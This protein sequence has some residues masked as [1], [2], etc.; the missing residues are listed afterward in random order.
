MFLFQSSD[1][2]RID[3]SD[4]RDAG[5]ELVDVLLTNDCRYF[6]TTQLMNA[7]TQLFDSLWSHIRRS[8]KQDAI[9][10]F[11][12]PRPIMPIFFR[13]TS[14]P[15][16]AIVRIIVGITSRRFTREKARST[17]GCRRQF[18]DHPERNRSLGFR[19]AENPGERDSR[20]LRTLHGG[21]AQ[22]SVGR[23]RHTLTGG[24]NS[25]VK[26]LGEQFR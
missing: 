13:A 6:A 19:V 2:Y 18:E 17:G 14:K 15:A 1:C 25:L 26:T 23:W 21:T 3:A 7:R 22:H 4:L 12:C 10:N 8:S 24:L 9:Q 11:S 16:S 5:T 20:I